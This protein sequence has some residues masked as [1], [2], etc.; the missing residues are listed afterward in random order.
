MQKNWKTH[1][2]LIDL[3]CLELTMFTGK[4][5]RSENADEEIW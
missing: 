1:A 5:D 3:Q 2:W 4:S